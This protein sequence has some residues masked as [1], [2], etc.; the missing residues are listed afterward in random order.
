MLLVINESSS[1]TDIEQAI[2]TLRGKQRNARLQQ[3][4]DEI[5]AD[6]NDLLELRKR[7]Q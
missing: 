6:I 5:D 4:R 2:T 7:A 3:I 1:R